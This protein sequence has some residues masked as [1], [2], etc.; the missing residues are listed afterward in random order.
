MCLIC[1]CM[2]KRETE[3]RVCNCSSK[4]QSSRTSL[5]KTVLLIR[6]IRSVNFRAVTRNLILSVDVIVIQ[7]QLFLA[8]QLNAGQGSSTFLVDHTQRHTTVGRTPLDEWSVRLRDPYLITH[9]TQKR[10]ASITPAGFEII[11]PASERP[12]TLA[13][14]RSVTGITIQSQYNIKKRKLCIID[15]HLNVF[16]SCK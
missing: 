15:V 6:L 1:A 14:D 4:R 10:Q 9:N 13:L 2:R 12:W 16:W 11:I 8:Q 3:M 7:S 5:I